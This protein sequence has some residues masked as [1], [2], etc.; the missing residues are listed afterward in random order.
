[1]SRKKAAI[2]IVLLLVIAGLVWFRPSPEPVIH[3]NFIDNFAKDL[4]ETYNSQ[5]LLE[6]LVDALAYDSRNAR[7]AVGRESGDLEI[8]DLKQEYSKQLI[9]QAYEARADVLTFTMDGTELFSDSSFV[10]G[11]NLWDARTGELR[12]AVGQGLGG[13]II[14]TAKG[15]Y[16]LLVKSSSGLQ[17][18]DRGQEALDPRIMSAGGVVLSLAV[19]AKTGLVAVGSA[20]G[21]IDLFQ[22][23]VT[24][25]SP[26]L[27]KIKT[28][29]PYETGNWVIALSFSP[30]G[31]SLYAVPSR[32][33]QIDEWSVPDLEKKGSRSTS[34]SFVSAAAFSPDKRLLALV[35]NA[36]KGGQ[37]GDYA[38][39]LIS[40]KSDRSIIQPVTTNFGQVVFIPPL[41]QLLAVHGYT[42]TPIDIPEDF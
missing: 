29:K 25:Q 26:S 1:M 36:R 40:L 14:Y 16:Y 15:D 10:G 34:G 20:S 23:S 32:P 27:E 37:G 19:Q 18:Y 2:L 3:P 28:I 6:S 24:D 8:W 7:L 12:S 39:E 11:L 21:T 42:V 4:E 41:K 9:K 33:G 5:G 17:I 30:D 35:G 31:K 22:F 38:I 13:P